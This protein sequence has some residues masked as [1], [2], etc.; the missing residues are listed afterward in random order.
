MDHDRVRYQVDLGL[1]L[2][3]V[4][5]IHLLELPGDLPYLVHTLLARGQLEGRIMTTKMGWGLKVKDETK[6]RIIPHLTTEPF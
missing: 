3:V 6:V 4:S 2:H 5:T 1:L